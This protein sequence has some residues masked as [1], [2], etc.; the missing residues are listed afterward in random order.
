MRSLPVI[1]LLVIHAIERVKKPLKSVFG[2][3]G[4]KSQYD[5]CLWMW[6][7][8]GNTVSTLGEGVGDSGTVDPAP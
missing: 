4:L 6:Q 5:E 1:G 3:K 8:L 2:R 7:S